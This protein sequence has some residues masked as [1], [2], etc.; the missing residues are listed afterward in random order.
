MNDGDF[1]RWWTQAD[2]S[3]IL[4]IM[5]ES[6]DGDGGGEYERGNTEWKWCGWMIDLLMFHVIEWQ[7]ML[8]RELLRKNE[9]SIL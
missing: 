5:I 3:N 4:N 9:Q 2:Q 8:M 1:G 7:W 6:N